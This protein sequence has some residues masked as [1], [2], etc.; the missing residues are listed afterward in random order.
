MN[1]K[2]WKWKVI[3]LNIFIIVLGFYYASDVAVNKIA[4]SIVYCGL[5]IALVWLNK[6]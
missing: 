3:I 6:D 5:A 2:S 4:E 1:I